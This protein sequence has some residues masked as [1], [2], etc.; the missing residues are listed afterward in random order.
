MLRSSVKIAVAGKGGTGKTSISGTLARSLARRG[1]NVLAIDC[2]SNPN[3]ATSLGLSADLTA[4]LRSM[5]KRAF[6]EGSTVAQLLAEY[7]VLAP[8]GVHLV[9]AAKVDQAGAG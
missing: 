3:L 5:P 8:D 9:L 4:Q 7:S 1:R 6:D 2:D